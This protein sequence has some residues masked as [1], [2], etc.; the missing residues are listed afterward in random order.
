MSTS[1]SAGRRELKFA[2]I[3]DLLNEIDRLVAA[4]RAG[5]LRT[6]GSW[7]AGQILGHVAAWIDYG[8]EGYP[9]KPPPWFIRVILR[10][11]VRKYLHHGGM[12]SGVRIPGVKE[13]TYGTDALS[14]EEGA[15]RLRRALRRLQAGEHAP[16][17]SPAFG[18]MSHDDRI[19]LNLRHAELH[20]SFLQPSLD[21]T[22]AQT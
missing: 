22:G 5:Q 7:T 8:Y 15:D 20:L 1:A 6:L 11:R 14:L 2:T 17:D 13:G 10:W 9:M 18:P 16:Y 21:R 12:P 19:Q 3:D 4:D